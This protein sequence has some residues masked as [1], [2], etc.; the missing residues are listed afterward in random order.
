MNVRKDLIFQLT[1]IV[2]MF[3]LAVAVPASAVTHYVSP[4][5]SIQ[6]GINAA[7]YGDTVEVAAGTYNER[8]TLKNGVGVIGAGAGVTIIDG[9]SV[10]SVVI[11]N[12]CDANTVLEGFMLTGG[13]AANGGGMYNENGMPTVTNCTFS[14]NSAIDLGG[15][16]YNFFSNPTVTNCTFSGNTA[17]E[18]G[19]MY[20]WESINPKVTNC[21][22]TGNSAVHYG[23]GML[24][25]NSDP[26]V[27][28]SIIWGNI[29]DGIFEM[30][31]SII[32]Y[33]DVQGG[34]PGEGNIEADPC[35]ID[36]ATG[37]LGLLS[38]S[39][40]VDA[41]N[42]SAVPPDSTDLDGDGDVNEPIPFDLNGDPRVWGGIVD[43][44]ACEFRSWLIHNITQ[45]RWYNNIQAAIDD[46]GTGDEI[47]VAPGTYNEAIDFKGKS[48]RLYST[49]GPNNTTIDATGLNS[50][51]VMCASGEDAKTVL[52]GFTIT[53]GNGYRG[54]G[55]YNNNSSS[56]TVTNCIFTGNSANYG[57]GMSNDINSTPTITNCTFSGNTAAFGGG[58]YNV[59]SR[60]T[61]INCSFSGNGGSWGGGMMNNSSSPTVTNCIFSTNH[62]T[63]GG[64]IFNGG[65]PTVI[66]NC[67]FSKN[68]SDEGGGM[69]NDNSSPT[70]TNCNFNGNEAQF[71]GGMYNINNSNPT[72][73]K[74]NF[75]SNVVDGNGGGM[76]NWQFSSPMVTNCTFSNNSASM[77]NGGGIDNYYHSN[78]TVTNCTF[79]GNF[80]GQWGGGMFNWDNCSPTVTNCILWGNEPNEIFDDASGSITVT[81]S[82]VQG[83]WDG[84]GNIDADPCFVDR[85]N[86]DPNLWNLQL[87]PDSPCIDTGDT[88]AVPFGIFV[89][90][91]GNPRVINDPAS[92]DK[93]I[94]FLGV[95]VDMGSYEF[96]LCRIAG[97]INCDG[98]VDFKDVAILCDNWLAGVEP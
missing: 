76:A 37:N 34:Y 54:G 53:G 55:M 11:S 18:G 9:N 6:A 82:D 22:F 57:G 84:T 93:G 51:V 31:L 62:A 73:I 56:P 2:L 92:P 85:N 40:C 20:N 60:P 91:D 68:E 14:G 74:C 43:M 98:D 44:G 72:V 80:S 61:V 78:P 15:G 13:N 65:S 88:T 3:A 17:N 1:V 70:V 21:T 41:G 33:S 35:F 50:S 95:T 5:Q 46:A 94:S 4:G 27:T 90:A 32:T 59:G 42:N 58:M 77:G 52:E 38:D 16:M 66:K 12:D 97:D 79:S 89:D 48:V 25:E 71:S 19:G 49:D 26:I 86:P 83:G 39:Q 96:Q 64:G 7:S 69:Y 30:G 47:E 87:K 36:A 24:N 67:T 45:D 8:I 10:G 28:N 29:P 81:Y 23:G 75:S 63:Q